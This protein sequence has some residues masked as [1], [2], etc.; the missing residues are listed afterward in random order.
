MTSL[1]ASV[2]SLLEADARAERC[3]ADPDYAAGILDDI[4]TEE[5]EDML[6]AAAQGRWRKANTYSYD[7]ARKSIEAWLLAHGWRI[8]AAAGAH[9]VVV[10]IADAWLGRASEPGPR[11]A[12]SYGASR[13]AR[14]DDEYPSPHAANRTDRELRALVLDN[15]RLINLVREAMSQPR[16]P[17]IVPTEQHLARRPER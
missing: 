5:C 17:A 13:K 1:P 15:A 7:A 9:A 16:T 4:I 6:H 12:R 2:T 10:S 14:H 3:P 11:I 8:R